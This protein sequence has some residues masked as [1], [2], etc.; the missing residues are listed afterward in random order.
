[1]TGAS[2]PG[3]PLK[4][5]REAGGSA[6]GRRGEMGLRGTEQATPSC[7]YRFCSPWRLL[8]SGGFPTVIGVWN[9]DYATVPGERPGCG[10]GSGVVP[11][12]V[13]QAS[14]PERTGGFRVL[15]RVEEVE[16]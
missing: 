1:M 6:G 4:E 3:L 16:A 7:G 15:V 5:T 13:S 9:R 2:T 12:V 8:A 11:R 10:R 14:R